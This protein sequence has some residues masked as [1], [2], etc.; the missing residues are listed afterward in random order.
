MIF[1]FFFSCNRPLSLLIF[2]LTQSYLGP[3][4]FWLINALSDFKEK[5]YVVWG[6]LK[7]LLAAQFF[8]CLEKMYK[9]VILPPTQS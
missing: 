8:L 2:T 5:H 6:I 7:T 9:L 1:F 4:L 3:F